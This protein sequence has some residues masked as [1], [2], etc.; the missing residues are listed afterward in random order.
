[1]KLVVAS[2]RLCVPVQDPSTI[3]AAFQHCHEQLVK[4]HIPH[5]KRHSS[6][7]S[8]D[9]SRLDMSCS[10]CSAL[11]LAVDQS[12]QRLIVA[13]SGLC[14]AIL[15]RTSPSRELT[16]IELA[17]YLALGHDSTEAARLD[18]AG[19]SI[20]YVSTA[21]AHTASYNSSSVSSHGSITQPA[22]VLISADG[23]P[24]PGVHASRLLGF[25]A[26]AAAGVIPG[27]VVT[28]WRLTGQE[29]FVVIGSPG[30]WAAMTPAEVVDYV[31]AALG[32]GIGSTTIAAAAGGDAV[33]SAA[34]AAA[35]AAVPVGDLLTLEAQERLKLKL[36]DRMFGVCSGA[37]GSNSSGCNAGVVPD[38]S[39]VVLLLND[40]THA[41]AAAYKL[42]PDHQR[43]QRELARVTR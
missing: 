15:A 38:V 31:A 10:G 25:T 12:Q 43:M 27:P 34:A 18:A 5:T 22:A 37:A 30:L 8:P 20:C 42:S 19:S 6:S 9:D 7:S 28:S 35:V 29:F 4:L 36:M 32:A 26:A 40:D 21:A 14:R 16:V 3:E 39:A 41:A 17:P 2:D 33:G 11:L 1:M 13:S 23:I 24:L